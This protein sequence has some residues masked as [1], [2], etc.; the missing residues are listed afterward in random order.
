MEGLIENIK[1][2]TLLTAFNPPKTVRLWLV[3]F[4][5]TIKKEKLLSFLALFGI[6]VASLFPRPHI[7]RGWPKRKKNR[8]HLNAR[9]LYA[10]NNTE[11][12]YM[13]Q[14]K[15]YK[16]KH[17]VIAYMMLEN[18]TGSKDVCA[19]QCFV[20]KAIR[21]WFGRQ[22]AMVGY[23]ITCIN[24]VLCFCWFYITFIHMKKGFVCLLDSNCG[25]SLLSFFC[26]QHPYP[27]EDQ[28][29][30]LAQ[31]TGLTILQVNNW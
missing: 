26:R 2:R 30:Q 10:F 11:R 24:I 21:F 8:T 22:N 16:Y 19:D 15:T 27:S 4:Y 25:F 18:I 29:K 20:P 9:C 12:E 31:D 14:P 13:D 5:C 28:K 3:L 6:C 1:R 23:I 17:D 7:V